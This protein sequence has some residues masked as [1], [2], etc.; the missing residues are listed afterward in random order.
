MP[1]AET[2]TM[3]PSV[4]ASTRVHVSPSVQTFPSVEVSPCAARPLSDAIAAAQMPLYIVMGIMAVC[5]NCSHHLVKLLP[6]PI[7]HVI[8]IV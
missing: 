3:L 1:T 8:L 2:V 4:H 5:I 6:K 7:P